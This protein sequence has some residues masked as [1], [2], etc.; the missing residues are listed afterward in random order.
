[1]ILQ[2]F[3]SFVASHVTHGISSQLS[4]AKPTCPQGGGG[5]IR[6]VWICKP[7]EFHLDRFL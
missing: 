7:V 5:G 6:E 1:M 3:I 2:E 4:V